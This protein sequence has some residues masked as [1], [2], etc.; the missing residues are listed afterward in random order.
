MLSS[1]TIHLF[2]S[3]IFCKILCLHCTVFWDTRIAASSISL[4]DARLPDVPDQSSFIEK[5]FDWYHGYRIIFKE[6]GTVDQHPLQRD[7][8][9]EVPPGHLPQMDDL[10]T[11]SEID[12]SQHHAASRSHV[13][14]STTAGPSASSMPPQRPRINPR[15]EI[16]ESA[17]SLSSSSIDYDVSPPPSGPM[18]QHSRPATTV[19]PP[20][21]RTPNSP[22]PSRMANRRL[23]RSESSDGDSHDTGR[24][25]SEAAQ[26]Q[27]FARVFGTREEVESQGTNYVSP[28]TDL[29]S[30]ANR[31]VPE[32]T[33]QPPNPQSSTQQ[34]STQQDLSRRP[35]L[36]PIP[37]SRFSRSSGSSRLAVAR[38]T[39]QDRATAFR[40]LNDNT[41]PS[42]NDNGRLQNSRSNRSRPGRGRSRPPPSLAT[43]VDRDAYQSTSPSAEESIP[44]E[45]AFMHFRA[46]R[47]RTQLSLDGPPRVPI[48][49][50]DEDRQ[51]WENLAATP[52]EQWAYGALLRNQNI[53]DPAYSMVNPFAFE[54]ENVG[55]HQLESERTTMDT[56]LVRNPESTTHNLPSADPN[57]RLWLERT[58]N[59]H[60]PGRQRQGID[61]PNVGV[62]DDEE[63]PPPLTEEEMVVERKCKV[64][65]EQLATIAVLPCGI[66]ALMSPDQTTCD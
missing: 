50:T 58:L 34:S 60:A 13:A 66:P 49:Q 47:H 59:I 7:R 4:S 6:D 41:R 1:I 5:W 26:Y 31:S 38:Q 30:H 64:C 56:S 32:H 18:N 20:P 35:Y 42:T 57:R 16:S 3:A 45:R 39:A 55:G 21:I 19:S 10:D 22:G 62:D 25:Q 27:N 52:Y 8:L 44:S 33:I 9:R 29:F 46:G 17:S 15:N 61:R 11:S 54:A 23:F 65:M 14:A 37:P 48:L 2:C 43:S 51:Q 24:P 36:A 40:R 12:H 28:I 63:R 53:D